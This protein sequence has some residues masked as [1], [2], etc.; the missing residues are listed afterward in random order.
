MSAE[1]LTALEGARLWPPI[2]NGPVPSFD[3]TK[4][5]V[6]CELDEYNRI[7][8]LADRRL[9]LYGEII[10]LDTDGC[11]YNDASTVSRLVELIMAFNRL[12]YGKPREE[13]KP[14]RLQIN[15]PGGDVTEGFALVSAIE[16]SKT[17][18]YTIN[19]GEWSSMAFLIGITG[20]KR[21]SLPYAT[22][23]LHGGSRFTIGSASEV[24]DRTEF[25]KRLKNEVIKPHIFKHSKMTPEEYKEHEREEF[26]MRPEDALRYGFIDGIVTDIDSIL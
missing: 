23:L 6:I 21:F 22:F 9:Y 1:E 20:D 15:S 26:Y 25:D 2:G 8:D 17:P 19:A 11:S 3:Q 5:K 10:S 18:V 12:D 4:L 24:E 7:I 14:I 13:R 16:L